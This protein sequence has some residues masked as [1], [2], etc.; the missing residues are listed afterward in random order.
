MVKTPAHYTAEEARGKVLD[1]MRGLAQYWSSESHGK[2]ERERM[3]GLCFSILAM[4]DGCSMGLP[5][6]DLTL[7][8][9][10]SDEQY[11]KDNGERWFKPGMV[12]NNCMLHDEWY[13][14]P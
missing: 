11:C 9:H 5:A 1:H 3:E 4:L 14:K 2:T 6:M 10:P 8:P 12:I 7:L 13:Q